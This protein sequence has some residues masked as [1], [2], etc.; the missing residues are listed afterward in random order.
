MFWST[1]VFQIS[2]RYVETQS[3]N[4]LRLLLLR[5]KEGLRMN[6]VDWIKS[7]TTFLLKNDGFEIIAIINSVIVSQYSNT[8]PF[9]PR[10]VLSGFPSRLFHD[11]G[12]LRL[13]IERPKR[14]QSDR[15]VYPCNLNFCTQYTNL[16]RFQQFRPKEKRVPS[17]KYVPSTFTRKIPL[18]TERLRLCTLQSHRITQVTWSAWN[19]SEISIAGLCI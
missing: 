14:L 9:F 1:D 3:G 10:E 8:E 19:K 6:N 7:Y 16:K 13:E 2:K 11:W 4:K 18:R 15:D 17:Y 12:L 5:V